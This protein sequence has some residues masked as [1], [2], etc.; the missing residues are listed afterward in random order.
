M[1]MVVE[2]KASTKGA[3]R[4]AERWNP[5]SADTLVR[6]MAAMSASDPRRSRV[7]REAIEAWLPLARRLARRY[8]GRGEPVEDLE[9]S[10]A[11]A[12]IKAIDRFDPSRGTE[13]AS[14]AV[15]TMLGEIKRHFRDQTWSVRVP[16]SS[17]ELALAVIHAN[18]SLIGALGRS[19][20]V[21]EVAGHLG[22]SE[23]DVLQGLDAARMYTAASLSTPITA[24]GAEVLGD[25]IGSHDHDLELAELRLALRSAFDC[26]SAREQRILA[27][28]FYGNLNQAEIGQQ[29]GLSQMHISRLISRALTKLRDRL[30]D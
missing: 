19:P 4:A 13:F 7:R 6:A 25:T 16:R 22:V 24:D 23:D 1:T 28:R 17:Q 26:L 10:A 3:P 21:T 15:P 12:L 9:Q 27:L 18:E 14:F 2:D 20:T 8:A 5:D 29:V 30:G 11:F